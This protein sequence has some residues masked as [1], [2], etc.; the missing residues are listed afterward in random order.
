LWGVSTAM[1]Q[2]GFAVPILTG[3]QRESMPASVAHLP[4]G[5]RFAMLISE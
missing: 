5:A 3:L 2:N 4:S 1:K